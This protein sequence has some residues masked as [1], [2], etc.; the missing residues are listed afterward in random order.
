MLLGS[1]LLAGV[2]RIPVGQGIMLGPG[3]RRHDDHTPRAPG[4][5]AT[6]TLGTIHARTHCMLGT[7]HGLC[8]CMLHARYPPPLEACTTGKGAGLGVPP[9][10]HLPPCPFLAQ[11][12]VLR[13]TGGD[14]KTV[15][16]SHG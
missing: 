9:T 6:L 8:I 11:K 3:R 13:G 14:R 16:I 15:I 2:L 7:W 1:I 10:T 4:I 5:M 12:I